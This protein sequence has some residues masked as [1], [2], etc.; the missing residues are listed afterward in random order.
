MNAIFDLIHSPA[1]A[2]N[3]LAE[4]LPRA[5]TFFLTYAILQALSGSAGGLLQIVPLVVYYVKLF[6]LGSTPRSVYTI[7]YDL[8]DVFFGTLF[9]SITL[10]TVIC[11]C[12]SESYF[13]FTHPFRSVWIH[14]YFAYYQSLG[15]C[16]I[17]PVLLCLEI[18]LLMA[19]WLVT[20]NS[21]VFFFLISLFQ[22]NLRLAI[23]EVSSSPRP[24]NTP[25]WDYMYN[26]F[27]SPHSSS[28]PE[29]NYQMARQRPLPFL[30]ERSW[31]FLSSA[32]QVLVSPCLSMLLI[33]FPWTDLLPVDYQ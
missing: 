27:V 4:N 6:I 24:F 26:K 22:I 33:L 23:P 13:C 14:A 17:L 3:I 28:W 19:A 20:N 18:S 21:N 2:P 11:E 25:L 31:L 10:L 8:R 5:S 15:S 1:S 7:K 9:P 29:R 32:R 16:R 30:R 12:P